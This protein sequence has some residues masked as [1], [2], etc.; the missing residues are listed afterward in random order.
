LWN[1]SVHAREIFSIAIIGTADALD[2]LQPVDAG[3]SL[4][5]L[6]AEEDLFLRKFFEKACSMA[7]DP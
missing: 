1:R 5:V 4:R 6:F 7:R 2:I 3:A